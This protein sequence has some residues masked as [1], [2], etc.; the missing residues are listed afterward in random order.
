MS[1]HGNGWSIGKPA[2]NIIESKPAQDQPPEFADTCCGNCG[3]GLCY[4]DAMTG[5]NSEGWGWQR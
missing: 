5:E 1:T 2:A 4:V 3:P